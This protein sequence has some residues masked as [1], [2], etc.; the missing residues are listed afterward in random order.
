[1]RKHFAYSFTDMIRGRWVFIYLAFFLGITFLLLEFTSDFSKVIVT[2]LNIVLVL[3]PLI[4]VILGVVYYYNSR[5]FIQ[6]L[7]AQPVARTSVLAG[8]YGGLA[9]SLALSLVLGLGIPF[10]VYGILSSPELPVFLLL[11]GAGVA[12]TLIFSAISFF[13]GIRNENRIRGFGLGILI[14]LVLAIAYDGLFLLMLLLF[15]D[16]PLEN[17]ALGASVFNPIDLSRTL[18]LLKLDVSALMG[19]TNAVFKSFFGSG[20]GSLVIGALL[21][22]WFALPVFGFLRAAK[23]KDW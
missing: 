19:Y 23:R 13:I 6:L 20:K 7:L 3:V 21:F 2:L 11:L 4:S 5:E 8:L 17:F 12:L 22:L 16:Y 9:G 15:K 14:W 1:M 10:A 18:I